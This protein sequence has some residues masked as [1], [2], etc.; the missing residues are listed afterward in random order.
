M[1]FQ[2]VG[3]IGFSNMYRN[4]TGVVRRRILDFIHKVV[5]GLVHA[6]I[7]R[8][9]FKFKWIDY[10]F[11]QSQRESII[12][13]LKVNEFITEYS[14]GFS[15]SD[16]VYKQTELFPSNN[17]FQ[18]IKIIQNPDTKTEIRLSH[19]SKIINDNDSKVL[20]KYVKLMND[21]LNIPLVKFKRIYNNDKDNG[22][23]LYSAYQSVSAV[24][25]IEIIKID[26]S[27]VVELD[28][29][30]NH[31]NMLLHANNRDIDF[32]EDHY[33]FMDGFDMERK[34]VKH[35]VSAILNS[36]RQIQVLT[37]DM[38]SFNWS[39]PVASEFMKRFNDRFPEIA[40]LNNGKAVGLLLQKIEGD[41][42]MQ[43]IT[44]CMKS[45]VKILPVHDSIICKTTDM[46]FIAEN[47][48]PVWIHNVNLNKDRLKDLMK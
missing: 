31:L 9:C 12:H 46:H 38:G 40:N 18:R 16:D 24:N 34:T 28:Y 47:M 11:N 33:D 36:T 17:L 6:F 1:E 21:S 3:A 29:R 44:E 19:S 10:T 7:T 8:T 41:I 43:H 37:S 45:D 2:I 32:H 20:S 13:F 26:S 39:K 22:G 30:N 14:R 5:G 48:K 35:A 23:R 25:R 42:M 15:F 4:R 27:N